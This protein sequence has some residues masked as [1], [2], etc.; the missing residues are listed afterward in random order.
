MN[1][2]K[3]RSSASQLAFLLSA[4]CLAGGAAAQSSKAPARVENGVLVG[5]NG[6]TLYTFDKDA[7]GKS[8]C[9]GK[10]AENWPPLYADDTTPSGDFS[11]ITRDDGKKQVA[12][13]GKPLYYWVK[14]QKPGD[15]TGDGVNNVWRVAK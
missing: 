13:K 2:K 4:L 15:R 7:E 11:V 12:Y 14:D 3:M 10:C 5:G 8:M 9:N 6:M 1:S